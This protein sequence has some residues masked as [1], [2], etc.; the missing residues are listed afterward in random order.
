MTPENPSDPEVQQLQLEQGP[1]LYTEEGTG[2][3]MVM[4]HG[5][6]GSERDFR[7]LC[8]ALGSGYRCLRLV[9]PGFGGAPLQTMPY[10]RLMARGHFVVEA[11]EALG[12]ERALILG[13]SMGGAIAAAAAVIAPERA[14]G[15]ALL[16]S[17]GFSPHRS[18]RSF[19]FATLLSLAMRT[20]VIR[21]KLMPRLRAESARVGFKGHDDVALAEMIHSVA[22]FSFPQHAKNLLQLELP[23]MVA[24]A[25][26]DPFV[27]VAISKELYWRCPEGPR[28][29]FP[30]GGH[31]IQK[32]RAVELA[33]ALDAWAQQLSSPAT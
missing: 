18:F 17:I 11:M 33:A 22:S 25:R 24:C 2:F 32:S 28:L 5:I 30:D 12:V 13:H 16:A 29:E 23:T 10:P 20:P 4:I 3:P 31:N 15:L 27:E 21:T 8:S 6:P 9:L 26:D 1:L 14:A 19:K 7:W